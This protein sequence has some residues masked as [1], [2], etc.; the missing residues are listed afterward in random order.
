[1]QQK[2]Q[3]AAMSLHLCQAYGRGSYAL[4]LSSSGHFQNQRFNKMQSRIS[5]IPILL[6][7]SCC[8][9]FVPLRVSTPDKLMVLTKKPTY[10]STRSPLFEK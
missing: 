3:G 10:F 4:Y 2:P 6:I 9:C 7:S 5:I 1:M 8:A